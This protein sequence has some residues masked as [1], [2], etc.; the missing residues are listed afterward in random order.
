MHT[1]KAKNG[2]APASANWT[3]AQKSKGPNNHVEE[4]APLSSA[5][6]E[7]SASIELSPHIQ[8]G[9]RNGGCRRRDNKEEKAATQT[10]LKLTKMASSWFAAL[11]A[12]VLGSGFLCV[13]TFLDRFGVRSTGGLTGALCAL[14]SVAASFSGVRPRTAR[15][16]A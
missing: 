1:V 13:Y 16:G 11:I 12:L 9:R 10:L 6:P 8:K 5:I 3:E 4:L 15:S 7:K 2:K 14:W